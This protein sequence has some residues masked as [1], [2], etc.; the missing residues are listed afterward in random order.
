MFTNSKLA[1]S[2]R[3]A[4]VCGTASVTMLASNTTLAAEAEEQV[5]RIQITGSSI[6]RT[7]MEGSLPITSISSADIAK[8]GVTSVPDLMMQIPQM[9]GFLTAS[10]SVGGGG[11]G[12]QTASLRSLGGQYTLVLINGRRVASAGSG[13]AVDLNSIPLAAIKR[14]DVLTDG[15]SAIYGSDAIVGVINFIMKDDYQGVNINARFDKPQ[16]TGGESST[17]SITGGY[18]DLSSDGFNVMFSYSHDKQEE[19]KSMD[20]DFASTGILPFSYQGTDVYLQRTSSNAIPANAYVSFNDASG[21]ANKNFNP[22]KASNNGVCG[23][24]NAPQGDSCIYDFTETLRIFP[25]STRDNFFVQGVLEVNDNI[26]LFGT[27]SYSDFSLISRIAPYPT[28]RFNLP[29]DSSLVQEN[30]FPHLTAEQAA[31]VSNVAVAW[32]TRPGGNRTND[33]QT[34]SYSYVLGMRGD[35]GDITYDLAWSYSDTDQDRSYITGYPIE[36]KLMALLTSGEVNIFVEPENLSE[37]QNQMVADTMYSGDWT[38]TKTSLNSIEGKASMPVFE[39]PAGDVYIGAGFDYRETEY[40]RTA[41]EANSNEII[42]LATASPEFD[43]SR[44][45]YGIYF[46][47]IAPIMD[48][49]EVTGAFRYDNIGKITDNIA[50]ETLNKDEDDTT[51][52]LAVSYRPN[53]DWLIRASIGTGFKSATLRQIGEPRIPFGVTSSGYECPFPTSDARSAGCLEGIIQYNVFQE[54]FADLKPETSE[55]KSIGFVYAP[56]NDFSFNVDW[57]DV[58]LEDQVQRL[59]QNQIFAD[60][61]TYSNLFT[62]SFNRGTGLDQLAII[63]A[64]VN[65]G[66][67]NN[68]GIDYGMNLTNEFSFGTLKTSI[69]GTYVIESNRLRIGTENTFDD[70]LDKFGDDN[71]VT[72]RNVVRLTNT[73]THGDFV[74]SLNMNFRNGYQDQYHAGGSTRIRLRDDI[75]TRYEGGVQLNVASYTLFNYTT[76]YFVNDNLNVT[77]GI[78]NLFDKQPPLSLRTGGAGHQVGYDPRYTDVLGRTF[79]LTADYTF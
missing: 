65:I 8:S 25:E 19:L 7:D 57:W 76:Q 2:V 46:E 75:A 64:A 20:R 10:D 73:F 51:Y 36:D 17:F 13:S 40:I 4:I 5:E 72:F 60:P 74:H 78:N 27:A 50:K 16:E 48:G 18:G 69:T 70:S 68:E 77:L 33:N 42:F 63:Q 45:N 22:F 62:T 30:V 44:E 47:A 39:L 53:D 12:Q 79:Y 41:S 49:L 15:A 32:R 35:V 26:E 3:L 24:N 29:V 31:N 34:D 37:E 28:L 38:V 58:T 61:V 1:K 71:A 14:V 11:G 52:K 54:G 21:L 23:V 55:Q 66:V 9:Q 43:M 56:S 6:K 67:S 59:T